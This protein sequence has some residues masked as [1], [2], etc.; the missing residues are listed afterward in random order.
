MTTQES[1]LSWYL[2]MGHFSGFFYIYSFVLIFLGIIF[3]FRQFVRLTAPYG[4][5]AAIAL[6]AACVPVL[7]NILHIADIGPFAFFDPTPFSFAITGLILFW[8]TIQHEFLNIIPVARESVIESMNDGY[9]VMDVSNSI[10]D[11]NKAALELAGKVRK[12]VMGK[13]LKLPFRRGSG[14]FRS[15]A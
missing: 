8:G 4:T 5:Q 9:I 1:F 11:I 10:V 3:F 15:C 12:E 14:D 6:T 7:G 13:K 2:N